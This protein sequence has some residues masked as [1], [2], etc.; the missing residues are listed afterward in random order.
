MNKF[1]I[2]DKVKIPLTKRGEAINLEYS[3][4]ISCSRQQRYMFVTGM[5]GSIVICDHI[6]NGRESG[7]YFYEDELELLEPNTENYQIY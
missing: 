5:E 7:D 1:R 3:N 2:G 4:V 6:E